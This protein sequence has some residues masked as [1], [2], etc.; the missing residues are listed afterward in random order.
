V[1]SEGDKVRMLGVWLR[2]LGKAILALLGKKEF[3][4]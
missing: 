3:P 1:V 2:F 4:E